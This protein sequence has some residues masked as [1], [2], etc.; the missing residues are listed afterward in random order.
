[1]I[2]VYRHEL[3]GYLHSL[4]A[5]LFCAF[6]LLFVGIGSMMYNIQSAAA[7]F[8]YVLEFICIG[9]TVIVP[10]LTMRVLAEERR[11]KTDQLLY[12]LPLS[13]VQITVGK[14]ASVLTIFLVPMLVISVYPL[15]FSQY[16]DVYLPTAY[17]SLAA[18]FFLGAALIAIGMFLSSLT[19]NQG[20]AAGISIAALLLNY[21][22]VSLAEYAGSTA[23]G[24]M[25]VLCIFWVILAFLVMHMTANENLGFGMGL[26]LVVGTCA[27][28]YLKSSLFESLIPNIM[29]QLSLFDRFSDFVD[30]VFDLTN[31]VFYVTVSIFFLFLTVQSLEKRRY[32]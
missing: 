4:T 29:K 8:E 32:N 12:A 20:V 30:G 7:N 11:Q 22:S 27:V 23:F 28:Y 13:S 3:R 16:G 1:M 26:V 18:F 24:S 9:M 5:W 19:E 15:I 2:A 31:I 14:Y 17:G 21:F 25:T 6:F 10:V